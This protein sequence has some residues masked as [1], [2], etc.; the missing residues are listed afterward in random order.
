MKNLMM[1]TAL[2]ALT[3][4]AVFAEAHMADLSGTEFSV[5][6]M[7]NQLRV[8]DLIGHTIYAPAEGATLSLD[9]Q[10][11]EVAENWED[12]GEINDVILSPEGEI[13]SVNLDVGGF[14]GIGEKT[15]AAQMDQ[16]QFV[17]D[18]DDEGEFFVVYTGSAAML[19]EDEGFD[20]ASLEQTG[21]VSYSTTYG[22]ADME[23][24]AEAELDEMETEA[25][26]SE[27]QMTEEGGLDVVQEGEG[28]MTAD[29]EMT[30][31]TEAETEMT[32]DAGAEV[33]TEA[34]EGDAEM[35]ADAGAETEAVEGEAEMTADA[36]AET[37]A[38]E[39]EAEMTA[40]AGTETE[41]VEG[42][43]EMTANAGEEMTSEDVTEETALA[44][45]AT[46]EETLPEGDVMAEA[47]AS[48]NENFT[49][50][51]ENTEFVLTAEKLDGAPVY[52]SDGDE[53]GE[54]SA[55]LL[56]ADG[57]ISELVID[58]GGFLGLGE[59]PVAVPF[60]EVQMASNGYGSLQLT[61]D[62]TEEQLEEMESWSE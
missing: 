20:A 33:E 53:V 24:T 42:E 40:D 48:E 55:I 2:A 39:G 13:R 44:A 37:E 46:E 11:T 62:Q 18:A 34:V 12:I 4:T 15:I 8:S 9:G 25:T 16:L 10:V 43:A 35:T 58:V 23:T 26:G 30:E 60:S 47:D 50:L 29:A 3:G 21:D 52:G 28:E 31:G 56:T 54:V 5:E 6:T 51:S 17:P 49:P 59:K 38:V 19:E 22:A 1:T 7:Q 45:T 32:A 36:G 14:L 57:T 61:I 27:I 41:A